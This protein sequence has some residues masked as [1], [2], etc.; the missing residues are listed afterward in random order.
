[1]TLILKQIFFKYIYNDICTYEYKQSKKPKAKKKKE[2][3]Q[4]PSKDK[5]N[6][7]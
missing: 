4:M 1:M 5:T 2:N 3:W 7:Y 6:F